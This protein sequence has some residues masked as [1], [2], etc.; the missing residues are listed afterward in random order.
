MNS[1]LRNALFLS[2]EIK[3]AKGD[4]DASATVEFREA[5][6]RFS[7]VVQLPEPLDAS[8]LDKRLDVEFMGLTLKSGT[9]NNRGWAFLAAKSCNVRSVQPVGK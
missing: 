2:Q 7:T 6:E 1:S 8:L 4:F 5:G 9:K 3:P